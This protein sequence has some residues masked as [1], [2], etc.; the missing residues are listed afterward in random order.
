MTF[1]VTRDKF[2]LSF[3][4]GSNGLMITD[5]RFGAITVGET[6]LFTLT[7]RE[8]A[9][10]QEQEISS[11]EGWGEVTVREHPDQYRFFFGGNPHGLDITVTVFANITAN[12]V[13][14]DTH[15]SNLDERFS[16]MEASYPMP[17]PTSNSFDLFVA[18][19]PGRIINDL[20]KTNYTYKRIYPS[21]HCCMQYIALFTEGDALYVGHH[22]REARTKYYDIASGEG[23]CRIGASYPAEGMGLGANSFTLRG[24]VCWEYIRGDW[25]DTAMRYATFAK[26]ADWLP[27]I[28]EYGRPDTPDYFKEIPFWIMDFMPNIP[29]QGD[30]MPERLRY[31]VNNDKDAWWREA[32]RFKKALGLPVGYHIYNWHKNAFNIDYPHFLPAKDDF[33]AGVER[34]RNEGI[35]IAPYINSSSWE[36]HDNAPSPAES[37]AVSGIRAAAKDKDG[38]LYTK[39]YPQIKPDGEKTLLVSTCPATPVWQ[40]MISRLSKRIE[41]ELSV[42]GVYYDETSAMPAYPCTNP[43]HSHAPGN[44][45]SWIES[46]R[47]RMWRIRGEKDPKKFSF[48]ECNAEPYMNAFDGY[49][50]WHWGENGEVPAF[51]A[52]YSKY[53][54]ML[55]RVINGWRKNDKFHVRYTFALSFLFGQQLG[56]CNYDVQ[57]DP[58]VFN[59]LYRLAH[60]R[61]DLR[62]LFVTGTLLRPPRVESDLSDHTSTPHMWGNTDLVMPAVLSGAWREKNGTVHLFVFNPDDEGGTCTLS[63]RAS[64]YGISANNIPEALADLTPVLDEKADTLKLTLKLKGQ[65]AVHIEF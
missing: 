46:I 13:S 33:K 35:Y 20:P 57:D 30:N 27:T 45:G 56:W 47:D 44:S 34:V 28:G 59:F 6:P 41:D 58:T 18:S 31:A 43:T 4:K 42:D 37:F 19:G 52:I 55:G 22:D 50:T 17:Q 36:S 7:V 29:E 1:T 25:Y 63:L 64:E 9:T 21:L 49:L 26:N 48:S 5:G 16:V 54:T 12:G 32:I 11:C 62:A 38:K 65:D 24:G 61:Y 10:G 39:P 2:H 53:V 3:E 23:K 40:R 51:P 8:L 60:L 15:I 14:F